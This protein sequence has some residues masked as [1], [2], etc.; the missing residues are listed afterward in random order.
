[1]TKYC[2]SCLEVEIY[3]FAEPD[4]SY[5]SVCKEFCEE[6]EIIIWK[7]R[8]SY[9]SIDNGRIIWRDPATMMTKY[10]LANGAEV[11]ISDAR[12]KSGFKEALDEE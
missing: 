3:E 7:N 9:H 1:M 4:S 10:R 11:E 8:S 6:P 2:K 5:C 12:L